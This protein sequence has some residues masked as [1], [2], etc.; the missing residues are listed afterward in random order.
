MTSLLSPEMLTKLERLQLGS[1]RRL[2]GRYGG[3]HRS[4]RY[5]TSLDFADYREYHPGDD[6][7]RIDYHLY[8]RLDLLL[9]RLFEAEDDLTLRLVIDTSSSMQW[10]GKSLQARRL[11]AALGFVAL[12]RRDAVTVH[13]FPLDRSAPR[14]NGRGA[15]DAMFR[16]IDN[17]EDQ[18]PTDLA[19]ATGDLLSRRGLPGVTVVVSDLLTDEWE[20]A[21]ARLPS[22]G[23]QVVVVHILA[24]EET[25]PDLIGDLDVI[26]SETGQRVP[27]SLS[28]ERMD[29]YRRHVTDWLARVEAACHRRGSVYLRVMADDDIE[30]L[31]FT[32][33]RE[34]GVFR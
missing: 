19:R 23:D 5:G 17:L 20:E 1:A 30:R 10:Y 15:A 33:W 25:D 31:L 6:F 16:H 18:G 9:L 11:A 32:R 3:G 22:R 7:R 21:L 12:V 14:F 28:P 26:D 13:S 27:V 29:E 4:K 34:A 2:A 24:R 8:A